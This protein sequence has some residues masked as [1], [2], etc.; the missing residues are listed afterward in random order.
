MINVLF[1]ARLREQ[2]GCAELQLNYAD[3]TD[4]DLLRRQLLEHHPQWQEFFDQKILV[5]INQTLVKGNHP[6]K[7]GDEVAFFP[8]VTGG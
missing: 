4:T 8:P 3:L 5:A 1:F 7:D 2:L 6:L